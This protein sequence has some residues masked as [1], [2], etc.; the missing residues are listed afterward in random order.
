MRVAGVSMTRER[1]GAVSDPRDKW[2]DL[3]ALSGC[4]VNIAWLRN[5]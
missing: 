3:E 5:V 4:L 1:G 2:E